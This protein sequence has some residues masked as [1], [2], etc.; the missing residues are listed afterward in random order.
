MLAKHAYPATTPRSSRPRIAAVS[1]G[2]DRVQVIFS[3]NGTTDHVEDT[4]IVLQKS[5]SKSLL[6]KKKM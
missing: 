6:L 1:A 2:I 3:L 5:Q 4:E